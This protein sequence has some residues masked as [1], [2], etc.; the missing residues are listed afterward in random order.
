MENHIS[1]R[2]SGGNNIRPSE[3]QWK[4]AGSCFVSQKSFLAPI[5]NIKGKFLTIYQLQTV[6]N[7]NHQSLQ[8]S[9]YFV[10]IGLTVMFLLVV[11]PGLAQ[12]FPVKASQGMSCYISCSRHSWLKQSS[13]EIFH[14]Y[15]VFGYRWKQNCAAVFLQDS[16]MCC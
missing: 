12:C 8:F 3:K 10:L 6:S 14:R 7:V 5:A 4:A 13:C 1:N 16:R 9:L 11:A 15:P 2:T